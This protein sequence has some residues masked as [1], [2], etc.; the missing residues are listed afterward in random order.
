M[1]ENQLLTAKQVAGLLALSQRQVFRLNNCGKLPRL[2]RIGGAERWKL[3]D[4]SR[5]QELSCPDCK[6]F[7]AWQKTEAWKEEA[8]AVTGT[9]GVN[10]KESCGMATAAEILLLILKIA[11]VI[12]EFSGH[13]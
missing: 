5:W 6:E 8:L 7:E 4:I 12:F 10:P 13:L 2:V 9:Q 1:T 11:L 3:A